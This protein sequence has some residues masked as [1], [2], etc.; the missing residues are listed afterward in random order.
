[1]VVRWQRCVRACLAAVAGAFVI[2]AKQSSVHAGQGEPPGKDGCAA[3][4]VVSGSDELV[5]SVAILL[6][7][8]GVGSDGRGCA[9][10]VRVVRA[11]L[12]R[13]RDA[14]YHRLHI[15]DGFGR[16]SDRKIADASTAAS[17]IESWTLGE[18]TDLLSPRA[19]AA[20][21]PAPAAIASA[22]AAAPSPLITPWAWRVMVAGEG[23]TNLG[24]TALVGA[25][26]TAC[27]RLG[28]LCVGGRA[29][30]GRGAEV[31][32]LR[33]FPTMFATVDLTRTAGDLMLVASL[34]LT[35]RRFVVTPLLGLGAGWGR[36]LGRPTGAL[37]QIRPDLS[38]SRDDFAARAEAAAMAGLRLGT[39]W[40]IVTEIGTSVGR[41]VSGEPADP[42]AAPLEPLPPVMARVSMGIEYAR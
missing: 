12:D 15:D 3:A 34:P 35:W 29:R 32:T 11:S 6:R 13:D 9:G 2:W 5:A 26:A 36:T 39:R 16:T 4:A 25:G 28:P 17:L 41:R 8:H 33:D 27:A 19:L 40:A 23:A 30:L 14:P 42:L 7:Q 10:R 38:A 18:D 37:A 24:G 31:S 20:S 1:M 22:S 21:T